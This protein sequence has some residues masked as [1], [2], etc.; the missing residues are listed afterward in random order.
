[1]QFIDPTALPW[2]CSANQCAIEVA[3]TTGKP[4]ERCW[5]R[6]AVFTLEV[7][8]ALPEEAKDKACICARCRNYP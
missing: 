3:K 7:L 1:M 4:L 6:V 8:E 2:C 5:C